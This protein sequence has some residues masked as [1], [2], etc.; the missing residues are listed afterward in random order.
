MCLWKFLGLVIRNF[1]RIN[2]FRK[3]EFILFKLRG[4]KRKLL[5]ED[6]FFF[7]LVRFCF[8]LL[9]IDLVYC[10]SV[11]VSIVNDIILIWI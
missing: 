3:F 9:Y 11:L 2:Y 8:G 7:I 6:E 4:L 1:F 10:F 5:L